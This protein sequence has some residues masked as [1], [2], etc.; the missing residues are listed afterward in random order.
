MSDVVRIDAGPIVLVD[1]DSRGLIFYHATGAITI[2]P[3]YVL[4]EVLK[5]G[6]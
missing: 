2:V 6:R 1:S 5:G 4:E 3:H